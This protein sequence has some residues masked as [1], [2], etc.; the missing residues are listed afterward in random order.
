LALLIGPEFNIFRYTNDLSMNKHLSMMLICVLTGF[1]CTEKVNGQ[2]VVNTDGTHSIVTGNIIVNPDGTHSVKTGDV[3]VNPNG[4][5]S[6]IHGNVLVAPDGS[7]SI[8]SNQ[9]KNLDN[10]AAL[11]DSIRKNPVND[12]HWL[13]RLFR[14]VKKQSVGNAII[15]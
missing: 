1:A 4:S 6:T 14:P 13:I 11:N 3:M 2:V 5:H 10:E 7:H 15:D 9:N 8:F 12:D